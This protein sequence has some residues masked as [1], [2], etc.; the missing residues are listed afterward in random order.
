[1]DVFPDRGIYIE[2]DDVM[3]GTPLQVDLTVHF[4]GFDGGVNGMARVPLEEYYYP[5][6]RKLAIGYDGE[7][8][9]LLPRPDSLDVVRLDFYSA[10]DPLLPGAAIPQL[11]RSP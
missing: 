10:L 5:I 9:A 4:I 8:Y 2:R 3:P 6:Y 1:M 7:V 11:V